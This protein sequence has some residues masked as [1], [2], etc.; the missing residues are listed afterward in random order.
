[1][2]HVSTLLPYKEND[3][4]QLER[5]RHIG[6]DMVAVVFQEGNTPFAPDMI[7]SHFLHAYI[8]VQPVDPCTPNTR[9]RVSVTA[10]SDVP[11]FGPTL[12]ASGLFDKGP[13]FK[14]FLLTKLINAE[15]ACYKAERFAKLELRTR[16]SL[17]VS[18]MEE[19]KNRSNA[20]LGVTHTAEAP[21]QENTTGNKFREIVRSVLIGR[22]N[23]ETV[24]GGLKKPSSAAAGGGG[25]GNALTPLSGRSKGSSSGGGGGGGRRRRRGQQQ[26]GGSHTPLQP[27]QH[28]QHPHGPLGERRLLPQL[29]GDRRAAEDPKRRLRHRTRIHVIR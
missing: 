24:G 22:K 27:G 29:H 13:G 2:F 12:P 17:L 26:R 9:Y 5:K 25:A 4:Q 23:Q 7:A 18:L 14:D 20:F 10:R 8:V 3:P 19:L 6:N 21:K 16:S 15:I 11:F 28:P 1:M